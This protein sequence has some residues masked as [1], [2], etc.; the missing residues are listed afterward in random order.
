MSIFVIQ[1]R[2]LIEKKVLLFTRRKN[3]VCLL[4]VCFSFLYINKCDAKQEDNLTQNRETIKI[5]RL[6]DEIII[7]IIKL[8]KFNKKE[9]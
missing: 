9:H 8:N 7:K 2:K 5:K 1:F 3:T 4:F 6:N